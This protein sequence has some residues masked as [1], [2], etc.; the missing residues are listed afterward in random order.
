MIRCLWC[1]ENWETSQTWNFGCTRV[2]YTTMICK[3]KTLP[4][5]IHVAS[6]GTRQASQ[7][8]RSKDAEVTRTYM[9]SSIIHPEWTS[10]R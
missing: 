6:P 8:G 4:L 2:D 10:S 5:L 3:M 9:P 1:P 7:R